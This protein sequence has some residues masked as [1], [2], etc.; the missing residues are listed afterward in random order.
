MLLFIAKCRFVK[1]G[2][3]PLLLRCL[4]RLFGLTL[5]FD[6]LELPFVV[7]LHRI[8][9]FP[10]ARRRDSF[11]LEWRRRS[12]LAVAILDLSHGY[13]LFVGADILEHLVGLSH[14][15]LDLVDVLLDGLA[16]LLLLR[17]LLHVRPLL[18]DGLPDL[19]N[20]LLDL[21]AGRVLM[22]RLTRS[23]RMRLRFPATLL[24]VAL[25]MLGE[26]DRLLTRLLSSPVVRATPL[27]D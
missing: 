5:C 17:E 21:F 13:G 3:L 26:R 11:L 15:L 1:P 16:D 19:P 24:P 23:L 18:L 22:G 2:K 14:L 9:F 7:H 25:S 10:R 6:R 20:L 27:L 12:E 4:F 8:Q